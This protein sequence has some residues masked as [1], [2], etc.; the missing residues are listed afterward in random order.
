MASAETEALGNPVL[1]EIQFAPLL[2]ESKTPS[3]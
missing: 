1:T 2:V 3:P